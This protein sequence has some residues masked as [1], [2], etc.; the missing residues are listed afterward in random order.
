MLE[1]DG[2]HFRWPGARDDLLSGVNLRIA[3]GEVLG[4]RGPSGCGKTTLAR[5]LAAH[6]PWQRGTLQWCGQR[7][8]LQ[9][10]GEPH[11]VQLV[12]QHAE[13][14]F[15]PR[16]RVRDSLGPQV[17]PDLFEPFGIEPEWLQRRPHELSGG[18]LQRLAIVRA[19]VP[20]LR[21]LIVDEPTAMHDAISQARLWRSLLAQVRARGI[22]TLAVAHDAALL[23]VVADQVLELAPG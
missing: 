11:V 8:P 4:L 18:E 14:A 9:A 6:L 3:P 13:L 20:G 15:N 10:A 2:L 1:V 5:L 21:L 16:L 19:L 23:A 22:A 12:M 7:L 17:C